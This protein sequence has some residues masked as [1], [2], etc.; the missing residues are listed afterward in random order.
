MTGRLTGLLVH[1]DG[2]AE[3]IRVPNDWRELNALI[4]ASWGQVVRTI[5][6]GLLLWIDEE[7]RLVEKPLNAGLSFRL[8]PSAIAGDGLILAETGHPESDLASLTA[9]Q[10][11][12]LSL[13]FAFALPT[14]HLEGTPTS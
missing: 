14:D 5:E 1:A 6:P 3:V 10:L 7:G 8:Y 4:G 12:R 11:A 13:W 2:T 9:D